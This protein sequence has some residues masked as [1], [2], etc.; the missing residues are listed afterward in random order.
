MYFSVKRFFCNRLLN[1]IF[2]IFSSVLIFYFVEVIFY[3]SFSRALQFIM[4]NE[5][6]GVTFIN[7]SIV[8]IFEMILLLIF[9]NMSVCFAITAGIS[10]ILAIINELKMSARG[11]AFTLNDITVAKEAFLVAGNYDL[12]I[13]SVDVK[14]FLLLLCIFFILRFFIPK[15]QKTGDEKNIKI[16]SI[17]SALVCAGVFV[18]L[19]MNIKNVTE[20]LGEAE[21]VFVTAE[22]YDRK[23]YLVGIARTTP[24]KMKSPSNYSKRAIKEIQDSVSIKKNDNSPNIIF[25]MNES[26]YDIEV[27]G[28][29]EFSRNPLEK[30]K[31]WQEKYAHGNFISPTFGGGTCNTEF[32][33]LTGCPLDNVREY[34]ELPYL[35]LIHHDVVSLISLMN[36]NGY[37]TT[38][39]HSNTGSYFNRRQIYNYMGF[40]EVYFTE[41]MGELPKEGQYPS[42]LELYK[43]VIETYEAGKSNNKPFFAYIITMQNHG[44]YSY[45]YDECGIEVL[46]GIYE[47]E[48]A[49]QTYANIIS[50][51]VDA[52]EYLITY[53][54]ALEDPTVIVMFGDHIPGVNVVFGDRNEEVENVEPY[55]L[56]VTPLV[57]YSNYDLP[58]E[59]WGFVNGYKL[60]AKV[61]EY[62][63]INM[64][65]FFAYE[66]ADNNVPTDRGYCYIDEKWIAS[67]EIK[68]EIQEYKKNIWLLAY[69]RLFGGKYGTWTE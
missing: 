59:D 37:R 21:N 7:I 47:N 61:L 3:Q 64:D 34:S 31:K 58:N 56:A 63:G 44:G 9:N 25:V 23:G 14:I 32:E 67:E 38:A 15:R 24:H 68:A 11:E 42:D 8:L 29:V 36:H 26:L 30:M 46:H 20:R 52:M 4:S 33:V 12:R 69:D 6:V 16:I 43:K 13:S 28:G 40:E 10:C 1:F 48:R 27:L 51:S 49:L 55:V 2:L 5:H 60:A 57:I 53:F 18:T 41:E 62:S 50:S 65:K 39:F 22:F 45:E 17:V 66:L 19:W 35:D 54:E